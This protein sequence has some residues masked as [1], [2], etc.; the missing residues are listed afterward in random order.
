MRHTNYR[1]FYKTIEQEGKAAF[2]DL[3]REQGVNVYGDDFINSSQAACILD[4]MRRVKELEE[5]CAELQG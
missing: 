3:A 5:K 4:L 1:D 2:D